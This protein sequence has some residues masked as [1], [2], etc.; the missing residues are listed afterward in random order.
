M[1]KQILLSPFFILLFLLFSQVANAQRLVFEKP[2]VNVGS[3]C[4]TNLSRPSSIIKVE[5][6]S[7]SALLL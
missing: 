3:H 1:T 4:G 5:S 2:T 7:C 6:V